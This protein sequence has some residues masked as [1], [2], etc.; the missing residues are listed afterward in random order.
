AAKMATTKIPI[1]FISGND[2]VESGLVTSL[3]RPGSN[4]TGVNVIS[5]AL[6]GKQLGVLQ[7]VVPA[8]T[9][10]AFLVNPTNPNS[11]S[12]IR[13]A[14]EAAGTLRQQIHILNA[15]TESEIDLAF[16]TL[17]QVQAGALGVAP[18]GL[19]INRSD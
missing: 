17:A 13:G 8:A 12:N 2:P 16:A 5:G 4:V 3:N 18:D 6:G 11:E 10:I 14:Q 9:S 1:V 7:E 15:R 19:F